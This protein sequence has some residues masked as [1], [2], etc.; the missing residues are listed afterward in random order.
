M[1]RVSCARHM[2]GRRR[3][4]RGTWLRQVGHRFSHGTQ[5][6]FVSPLQGSALAGI[7][8]QGTVRAFGSSG[9]PGFTRVGPSARYLR[10]WSNG[11]RCPRRSGPMMASR[12][13]IDGANRGLPQAAR[14][15]R[16]VAGMYADPR[17]GRCPGFRGYAQETAGRSHTGLGP[18]GDQTLWT[19]A[20]HCRPG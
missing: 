19:R 16:A 1:N 12:G 13:T 8:P 7:G 9:A 18:A 17:V 10:A 20:R 6:D 14:R 15:G 4:P 2:H 5:C 11:G 3:A